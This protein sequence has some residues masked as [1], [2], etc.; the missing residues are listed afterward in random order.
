MGQKGKLIW[1]N[2]KPGSFMFYKVKG[3][4]HFFKGHIGKTLI[5][6]WFN[7][8]TSGLVDWIKLRNA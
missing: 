8:G 6:F 7:R 3:R 5:V 4:K 1:A 2:L